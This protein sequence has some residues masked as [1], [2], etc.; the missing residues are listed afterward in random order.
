M[1]PIKGTF[2]LLAGANIGCFW[3][4]SL[5]WG[6]FC[7]RI[8]WEL[9]VIGVSENIDLQNISGCRCLD[10]SQLSGYIKS[11]YHAKDPSGSIALDFSKRFLLNYPTF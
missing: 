2:K 1:H 8:S 6:I 3:G 9:A 4:S 5:K 7:D 10:A 11:Q